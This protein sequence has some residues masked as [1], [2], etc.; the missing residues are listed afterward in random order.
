MRP[1]PTLKIGLSGVRGIV[2]ESLTPQL[3]TCFASA[4]GTYC[5][6]TPIVMGTDTRPSREMVTEAA[7][8]GLSS[9]GCT[10][11]SI[12]IAPVP[13]LQHHVREIGA[14]GG[15]CVTASHNPMEWN[16]LK[17]FG[18]EGIALRSN[19]LAELVDLYHQGVYCRVSA[20]QI[21][22]PCSDDSA[23][24]KHQDSILKLVDIDQ[25]R[26]K[27]FKVVADCCNGAASEVT[28]GFLRRLGC[29]VVGLHIDPTQ[30]FPRNP[31]PIKDNLRALSAAV[32]A[33]G[34]DIGLAQDA[35][36]DRLAIV[37]EKGSPLGEDLTIALAIR[38]FLRRQPGPVVVSL[39][40]SRIVDAVVAEY[41][42]PIYRT[43]VGESFVIEKMLA[44]G[45]QIGG[46]GSGGVI[47]PAAN[48][49]RDS[50]VAMSLLL[51]MLAMDSRPI[52][53]LRSELPS[54][55]ML[56]T[57]ISCRPRDVAPAIRLLRYFYRDLELDLT[58]GVKVHW[59][60]RWIHV[61]GSNT[62]PVIRIV[63]EADSEEAAVALVDDVMD[64]MRPAMGV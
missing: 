15:I 19:Q 30:P 51:E 45:A 49:C 3:V 64:Y 42:I 17:F 32:R 48:P 14:G 38:H 34:A 58:D 62:E 11:V 55:C 60:D 16:A 33:S 40:T 56:K 13:T 59:P 31:E 27:R 57:Q 25:I 12:G 47:V 9:V 50:F 29:E 41:D 22:N 43:K 6:P 39:S 53:Q 37:D 7:V 54:Y 10:P 21:T 1:S 46:E 35:D 63:A 24:V 2:G 18:A 28:P 36:A 26:S 44:C 61:R 52:S 20:D 8:A 4:F 23:P 5:G